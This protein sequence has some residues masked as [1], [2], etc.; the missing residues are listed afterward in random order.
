MFREYDV[1]V[2]KKIIENI[3][4]GTKGAIVL[5]NEGKGVKESYEVEFIDQLG[6]FLG[7]FTVSSDDVE[8]FDKSL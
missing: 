8:L 4:I 3:P 5:I 2:S 1:V 7:V 6:N